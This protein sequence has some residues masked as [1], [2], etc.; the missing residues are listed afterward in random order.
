[1]IVVADASP[2]IFLAKIRQLELIPRLFPGKL[3]VPTAVRDEL[4]ARPLRPDEENL[5]G[6]FLQNCTVVRVAKPRS[7]AAAMSR[8]DNAA[9]TLAIRKN[10]DLLLSDDRLIR[11]MAR[12]ENV[13]PMGTLGILLSA[14]KQDRLAPAATRQAVQAL[15]R[16]HGFRIRIDVFEAVLSE[17]A[18]FEDPTRRG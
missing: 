5:L 12:I 9:L 1:M 3:L 7:F 17:I 4:L 11:R 14:M 13:R 8:A 6:A 10:A 15:I 18:R 2:L 16:S